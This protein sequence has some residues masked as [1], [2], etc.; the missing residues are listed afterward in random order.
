MLQKKIFQRKT[1]YAKIM[2]QDG[3]TIDLTNFE[4]EN[5]DLNLDDYGFN[6]KREEALNNSLE[7]GFVSYNT[8]VAGLLDPDE[9]LRDLEDIEEL[10]QDTLR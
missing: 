10:E 6:V 8:E 9:V 5:M 7:G 3:G 1:T 4:E 2:M